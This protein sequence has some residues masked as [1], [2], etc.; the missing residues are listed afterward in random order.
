MVV[1]PA[2]IL[3]SLETVW[4]KNVRKTFSETVLRP[5]LLKS[6]K[7]NAMALLISLVIASRMKLLPL[8]KKENAY[9]MTFLEIAQNTQILLLNPSRKL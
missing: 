4:T 7:M 6:H 1:M 8:K 5:R 3:I 2:K 9:L